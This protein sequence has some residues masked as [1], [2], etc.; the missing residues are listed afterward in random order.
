MAESRR[1][2]VQGSP[3]GVPSDVA[4]RSPPRDG[5]LAR[6]PA[7]AGID[8]GLNLLLADLKQEEAGGP[9]DAVS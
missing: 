5:V 9:G 1:W 7:A 8:D 6:G 4:G 3:P 2:A